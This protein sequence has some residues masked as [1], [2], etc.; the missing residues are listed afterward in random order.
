M[1]KEA[2]LIVPV[3]TLRPQGDKDHRSAAL[4]AGLGVL[5]VGLAACGGVAWMAEQA[6]RNADNAHFQR[7]AAVAESEVVRRM[8]VYEHGLY[9]VRSLWPAS[10]SVERGEFEALVGSHNLT[11][12]LPGALGMGYIKRVERSGV[13]KFLEATRADNAP[14]FLIKTSGN[15]SDLYVVEFI[16]PLA[17]NRAA[18]GFDIGSE[19]IRRAAANR[20]MLTGEA[21]LT[22]RIAL[23]VEDNAPGFLYLLP[24]YKKQMPA[25]TPEERRTALEGWVLMPIMAS[26]VFDHISLDVANGELD[27]H[28][29]QGDS[30]C[31]GDV[32]YDDDGRMF[33]EEKFSASRCFRKSAKL[34]IG[35]QHWTLDISTTPRFVTTARTGVW[36]VGAGGALLS[37][38][39]ARL[40]WLLFQTAEK[41]RAMAQTMTTDL[42]ERER[43]LKEAND[44][45]EIAKAKAQEMAAQAQMANATKSEFLADMSHEIRTPMTAILGF[46][47]VLLESSAIGTAPPEWN[48]VVKTIKSSG[49]HL[50]NLINNILDLSKIEAGKMSIERIAC[51]PCQVLAEVISLMGARARSKGL[52]LKTEYDGPIPETIHTDPTRLRQIL[53]NLMANAIKFT[54]AGSVS[55]IV[56]LVENGSNPKLQF[57]VADTGIGLT[58]NERTRLFESFIQA[59]VSTARRFGGTGLGLTISRR[60]AQ[61]LGGNIFVVDSQPGVGTRFRA[62]VATGPLDGVRMLVDPVSATTLKQEPIKMASKPQQE[63]ALSGIRVLLVEDGPDNQRLIS[64]VLKKAGATFAVAE[65][66]LMA[67]QAVRD[68]SEPFDVILMDMQMPV[69]D[70][71]E[72]TR[73]LRR[74]GY[75]RPIVALTAHAMAEDRNKCLHAGCDDYA[76]KPIERSR[77]IQ[78][79]ADW[80]QTRVGASALLP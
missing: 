26:R 56:S 65:N 70:G 80:A 40:A 12:E 55:L 59:D 61:M 71:Y 48:E 10:K 24:V 42:Q 25:N 43:E 7:L 22:S 33:V 63:A 34:E 13:D 72:A 46:A 35:G 47:D 6:E 58:A 21:T 3:K 31:V 19:P 74:Q 76:T 30:C 73:T 17:A 78:Q 64:Y 39:A 79:V 8:R 60:L 49:A 16:E 68:A 75:L 32:I 14:N 29:F 57:D 18:Q 66:G 44:R 52:L 1:V 37:L 20:A 27:L 69:M 15:A 9:G 62:T 36:A 23:V 54:E 2:L 53:F 4:L 77:L 67:I 51:S 11:S 41:A 50:L 28:I 45:L 5:I 38:L